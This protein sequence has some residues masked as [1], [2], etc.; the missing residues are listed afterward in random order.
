M[1]ASKYE[2]LLKP[3]SE[4]YTI[5]SACTKAGVS[6]M[7]YNRHRRDNPEFRKKTDEARLLGKQ[8]NDDRVMS[9]FLRKI[10]DGDSRLIKYYLEHNV[11]PYKKKRQAPPPP[12]LPRMWRTPIG[13]DPYR[14]FIRWSALTPEERAWYGIETQE[15]FCKA[16]Q[17][18]DIRTLTAWSEREGFAELVS[19]MREQWMLAKNGDVLGGIYTSALNGDH[20]S[21]KLWL[22]LTSGIEKK[23]GAA[24]KSYASADDIRFIIDSL[25]EGAQDRNYARLRDILTDANEWQ[26]ELKR[27]EENEYGIANKQP[28]PTDLSDPDGP[29]SLV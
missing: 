23:R 3:L 18:A 6:R 14:Q 19:A 28:L 21:Q 7:F 1:K 29:G 20:R 13:E 9:A 25:P 24:K 16:Y 2:S 4:G 17:V 26:L 10:N 11:A 22:D 15:Q 5:T 8:V 27:R 12:A